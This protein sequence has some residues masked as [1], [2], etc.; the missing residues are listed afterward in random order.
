MLANV[1]HQRTV[2]KKLIHA[3]TIIPK[4]LVTI[5]SSLFGN[6]NG[7]VCMMFFFYV[8]TTCIVQVQCSGIPE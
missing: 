3:G 1:F 8:E 4:Y 7:S 2:L 5:I 6:D